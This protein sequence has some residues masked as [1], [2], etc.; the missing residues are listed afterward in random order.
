MARE[1]GPEYV[2]GEYESVAKRSADVDALRRA[3][4]TP[5]DRHDAERMLRALAAQ[6]LTAADALTFVIRWGTRRGRGGRLMLRKRVA[7]VHPD[8]SPML[9]WRTGKPRYRLRVSASGSVPYVGLPSEPMTEGGHWWGATKSGKRSTSR[10]RVGLVLHEFAH[11]L[12]PRDGHS[13]A[14]VARLDKLVSEWE[15][16]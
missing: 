6:Y 1:F 8:G 15:A 4:L 13:D 5:I 16:R 3:H 14:F 2:P 11:V 12:N 7:L 10:L 9:H